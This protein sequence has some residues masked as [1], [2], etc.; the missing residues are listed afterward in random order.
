[1]S[2]SLYAHI[3]FKLGMVRFATSLL[4]VLLTN[5]LNRVLIVEFQTPAT[6]I[7]FI[8]AFQH[9]ATPSGLIAGYFSDRSRGGRRRTPYIVAGMLLSIAVMPFFPAWGWAFAADSQSPSLLWMGIGLF[10]LFGVGT[11]IS[12]TAVNALLVDRIPEEQ[13]GS[14]MTLVWLL[15]LAGFIVGSTFFSHLVSGNQIH[16]LEVIFWLFSG[17]ALAITFWSVR[18]VEVAGADDM[19]A[20]VRLDGIGDI[21]M[22]CYRSSQARLFFLFLAATVFFLAMQTFILA[23]YGGVILNLPVGETAIFGV[24]TSYGTLLGMGTAYWGQKKN[25]RL[26]DRFF[27]SAGLLLGAVAFGLFSLSS[28]GPNP[29]MGEAGLWLL[30]FAKGFFNAGISFLTMR[31]TH[32]SFSGVFMGLW[33]LISGLALAAGE[34]AGGFLL[35]QGVRLWGDLGV[36]YAMVFLAEALGLL[37]CLVMLRFISV[38]TY[39]RQIAL[40]L[41]VRASQAQQ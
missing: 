28:R 38:P 9:L 1:M 21:L 19:V 10:T 33:N 16:R 17:I 23:P 41:G 6:L 40:Q 34:M 26:G 22:G 3:I 20:P 31:L 18:G 36:G 12:A 4:V 39:W 14:G 11:T 29:A 30:G 7:A 15:T 35:D 13:R 5:V 24:Y 27:L 25:P 37:G 32:P 8:F 2:V